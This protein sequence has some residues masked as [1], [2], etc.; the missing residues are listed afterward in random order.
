M[1]YDEAVAY[2]YAQGSYERTGVVASPSIDNI[3][4][5][6]DVLADPHRAFRTVHVTGTNGKGSTSQI[7]TRLL[8]A[9]GLR[10]GTYSSPH[11]ER[12]NERINI[13]SEPIADD[14]FAVLVERVADA[15]VMAGVSPSFFDLMTAAAFCW[16]A[17]NVVDVAVIEVGMLG[18]WDA[19][20][21]VDAEV[22]VITNVALDHMEF[23]GPTVRHIA[24][25]KA[26][27]I[28]PT[29]TVVLGDVPEETVPDFFAEP[30]DGV[31]RFNVDF[32]VPDNALALGGRSLH[33]RTQRADYT[34]LFLPLH[35]THQGVNAAV[36]LATVEEFFR[37][38]LDAQVV[39]EAFMDVRIAGRFE[40]LGYQP[41]VIVDGA[42]NPAGADV[43]ADVFFSDFDPPGR[44]ILV[45]GMIGT[46]DIA[47]TLGAM[48]ADDFDIVIACNAP[49]P[50]TRDANEIASVAEALGCADVRRATTVESAVDTALS[51][52]GPDDA[53]LIAGSFYVIGAAR[54]YLARKL[55]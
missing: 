41:L 23:A 39:A 13:D 45:V 49:S 21:I 36:A 4:R 17:D 55:P 40:I 5:L 37:A 25:E 47:D 3:A 46:R 48:R 24:K 6:M 30:N 16:F 54:P 7:I 11:L 50:R 44:R 20:N 52:A 10:V 31:V 1:T 2:L 26:G 22:A 33:L 38:P 18:R 53:V 19:T 28:K 29:S 32:D 15:Q 8:M 42:H 34:D 51:D 12:I 35:G 43:C 27:I 14:D 9:H